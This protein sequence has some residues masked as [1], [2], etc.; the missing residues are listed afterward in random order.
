MRIDKS[1]R[2]YCFAHEIGAKKTFRKLRQGK[3][4][5]V[6]SD[7]EFESGTIT[8]TLR[9]AVPHLTGVIYIVRHKIQHGGSEATSATFM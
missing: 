6:V 2:V 9:I 5:Y 3:V 4:L 7:F 8:R 1:V